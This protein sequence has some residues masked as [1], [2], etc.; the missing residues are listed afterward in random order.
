M[1]ILYYN[2]I[3]VLLL[4]M[5]TSCAYYPHLTGVPL[6]NKKGDTKIE[7]GFTIAPSAT[8]TVSHG[9]TDKI[10]IQAAGAIGGGAGFYYD[11]DTRGKSVYYLQGA[12]GLFKS[13]ENRNVLELYGGFGF[14]YGYSENHDIGEK[15]GNYQVYFAQFNFGKA[16]SEIKNT[17]YGLGLKMGYI[18]ANM[19]E[20]R[21]FD[22][23]FKPP[24]STYK[25]DG[26]L[27]EPQLFFRIGGEKLKFQTTIGACGIFR[28]TNNQ[29]P[30]FPLNLGLGL[31]YRF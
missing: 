23:D 20:N 26:V 3:I 21:N 27:V 6:I 5:A 10:A 15:F 31:S 30:I 28:N 8:A 19:T 18:H 7:G 4:L 11:S 22:N 29:F 14:G 2:C 1:R 9:L 24:Y 16:N 12:T 13:R 17:D 25:Y